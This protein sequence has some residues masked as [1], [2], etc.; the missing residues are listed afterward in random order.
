[1]NLL[2]KS[3]ED[4][5]HEIGKLLNEGGSVS[6]IVN[7]VSKAVDEIFQYATESKSRIN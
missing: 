6:R 1:M 4:S 5:F 7:D 2:E 3:E